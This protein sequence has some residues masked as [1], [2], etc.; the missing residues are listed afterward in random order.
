MGNIKYLLGVFVVLTA[1]SGLSADDWRGFRGLE[2]EGRCDS[3][4]GP[5][6]WSSS[7]NVVW[8]TA[9][10]GRGHSS[11]ILSGNDVYLTTTYKSDQLFPIEIIWDYAIFILTLLFTMAGMS[12][13]IQGLKVKQRKIEQVRQHVRFFLFVL[14][15]VGV[16]TVVLFGRNLLDLDGR[17]MQ[18]WLTSIMLVLCCLALSPL[19]VPLKSRQ[20]LL[21]SLLS[22]TFTV[23]AFIAFKHKGLVFA[24]GSLEDLIVTVALVLPLVFGFTLLTAYFLSGKRQSAM[25]ESRDDAGQRRPVIL[26]FVLTGSIGLVVALMPFFLLLYRAA[27]YEMSDSLISYDRI[28]PNVN[29]WCIAF[30]VVIVLVTITGCFRKSARSGD[31]KKLP[32]QGVFFVTALALGAVF[33][34]R[35]SLV[36]RPKE[37]V[38]AVICLNRDNGEILWTCEGL[39]GQAKARGRTVTH[40][41]ATP[42]TDGERIYGYFGVDGLMCVSP[43]GELLWKKTEPMFYSK[44]GAGTSPVAKDNVLIVVSDVRKPEKS[45]S[46]IIAFDCITG[47]PLWKKERK[48]H[49]AYA[50]YGTP[51][52]K[53]LNGRQVVIVHGWHDIKGYDLKTGQELW[54]YPMTHEGRHLVASLVSDAEHLYVMGAKQVRALDLSKLGTGSDPLLWSR[55]IAGEKG[56]TPAVAGG[57]LFLVT[58]SGVAFCLEAR[59]G[60]TLW[61]KRLGGRYYSCVVTM[62]DQALFTNESGQTTIVAI[63]KEFRQLAKNSLDEP[64]YASFALVGDQLFVRTAKYL[65][66]IQAGK[67]LWKQKKTEPSL[68]SKSPEERFLRLPAPQVQ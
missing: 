25:I 27:R 13:A 20:Q 51:L 56:S 50:A 59:T 38:R 67:P 23:P 36:E 14:F 55:T 44:Y 45:L 39:V 15:L 49:K 11:P 9:I 64:I 29:W 65:Y 34:I 30:Y 6:N 17:P 33:F 43:E 31:R 63:D 42:V 58:E 35:I 16:I 2:K 68:S 48:S 61:E 3:A 40:A 54:S 53:S 52:I 18:S 28:K 4:T 19:L 8:K 62:G 21:T 57:L 5:L 12:F 10:P 47:E 41:S 60:R 32:L 7:Q 46:S 66:C 22:L 37:F 1:I 24:F 26:H